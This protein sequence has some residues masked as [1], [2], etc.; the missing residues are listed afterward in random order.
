MG[1]FGKLEKKELATNLRKQ[2]L[3]YKEILQHMSVSKDTLSRWCKDI[4]LT[5]VQKDRLL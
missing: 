1:Y 4:V 5:E 2:G 3:S